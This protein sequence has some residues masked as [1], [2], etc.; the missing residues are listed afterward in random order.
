MMPMP[1]NDPLTGLP[2]RAQCLKCFEDL[3]GMKAPFGMILLDI[4]R[5]TLVNARDGHHVGDQKLKEIASLIA[6]STPLD[7]SVFRSGGDEFVVFLS[8]SR[9]AGVVSLA[10]QIKNTI[11]Q[12]LADSP[13]LT[14]SYL[15]PD[16]SHLSIQ[17]PLAISC[18]IAFYPAHGKSF[19][20][21]WQ[22][23]DLAM[24][25]AGKN[26][27]S[28]G[29]LAVADMGDVETPS[30]TREDIKGLVL[31]AITLHNGQ[32]NYY[33]LDRVLSSNEYPDC[34]GPFFG[35][36]DQLVEEGRIESKPN[37]SLGELTRYW[38]AEKIAKPSSD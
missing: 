32:W 30:M 5:F 31:Q 25:R 26:L 7:A 3:A 6:Q 36:L 10:M 2:T 8:G 33:Q 16:R 19:A 9:M 12:E 14:S 27:Q 35:E 13:A 28:G 20:D 22:A 24:Y 23:A 29:I 38:V 34:I 37:P 21:L 17:S 4:D 1:E 15:F 11:N 18:G